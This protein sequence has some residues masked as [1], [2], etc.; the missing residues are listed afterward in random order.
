MN[1]VDAIKTGFRKSLV[2]S[3]RASRSEFWWFFPIGLALPIAAG[4]QLSWRV[5]EIWGIWRL[6]VVMGFALPLLAASSRRLQDV[7]EEGHQAMFPFTPLIILWVGYMVLYGSVMLEGLMVGSGLF[8]I[9]GLLALLILVP[10]HFIALLVSL[11]VASSVIGMMLVSSQPGPNKYGP[12]PN[13]V[14]S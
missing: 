7:G 5:V 3:G 11:W 4:A 10:L 12:N 9:L 6:L 13:E 8:M 2:F 14:P 1:A